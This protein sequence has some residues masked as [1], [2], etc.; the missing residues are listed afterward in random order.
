[1]IRKSTNTEDTTVFPNPVEWLYN[2]YPKNIPDDMSWSTIE[3]EDPE[4]IRDL[5]FDNVRR[6]SGC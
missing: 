6:Y 2:N 3:D 4:D 5:S 1:M